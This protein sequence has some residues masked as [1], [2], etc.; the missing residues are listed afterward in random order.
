[1]TLKERYN[2]ILKKNEEGLRKEFESI[3]R[4]VE[5]IF[6]KYDNVGCVDCCLAS[7]CKK[8]VF[9]NLGTFLTSHKLNFSRLMYDLEDEDELL[10]FKNDLLYSFYMETKYKISTDTKCDQLIGTLIF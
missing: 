1:M 10:R 9:L 8:L 7:N 3:N 2:E 4:C 6:H 5:N